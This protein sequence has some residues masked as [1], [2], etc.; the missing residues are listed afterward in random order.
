MEAQRDFK[1]LFECFNAHRAEFVLVG[2]YAVAFHGAPLLTT[3]SRS[4]S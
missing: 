1:E 4:R 3:T 2:G